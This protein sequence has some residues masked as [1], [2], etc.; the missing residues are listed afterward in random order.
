[1][2]K[3]NNSNS[4]ADSVPG[5]GKQSIARRIAKITAISFGILVALIVIILCGISLFL[6]PDRLTRIANKEASRY[7]N[8][9]VYARHIEYSIWSSFPRFDIHTDSILVIS[10]TLQ[11][12]PAD[13]RAA[14]PANADSLASLR[15][16]SGSIN[17]IDL[18]LNRY[19]IHDVKVDGLNLN[20][21]AYNDSINNYNIIPS[22]GEKM[23]QIPYFSAKSVE[24]TNPG[25]LKY[26]SAASQTKASLGLKR[27]SLEHRKGHDS[28]NLYHLAIQGMVNA[29]SAGLRILSDFPFDL[30]GDIQLKFK[31]FGIKLIDYDINL[32]EL[33]SKLSMSIGIG[34]TPALESFD[35][36]ISSVNL[37]SL[38]EYIP[39]EFIPSLQGINTDMTISAAARLTSAWNFSSNEFPSVRV[40]FSTP[41][42]Q[43]DY[44]LAI[45]VSPANPGTGSRIVTYPLNYSTITGIFNFNGK[46]PDKSY[47]E[48]PHFSIST[49]GLQLGLR[50][51]ITDLTTLPAVRANLDLNSDLRKSLKIFPYTMPM[52][53]DGNMEVNSDIT[54]NVASLTKEGL[55]Q[56]L[57]NL[58]ASG[59]I[60]L[61]DCRLNMPSAGLKSNLSK[62]KI[63]F[64]EKATAITPDYVSDPVSSLAMHIEN[65][66][67]ISQQGN[68]KV[69]GFTLNTGNSIRGEVT[70]QRVMGGLPLSLSIYADRITYNDPQS[71]T[72]VVATGTTLSDSLVTTSLNS[73]STLL[74]DGF[75]FR[76]RE[77][78]LRSAKDRFILHNPAIS[79]AITERPGAAASLQALT[80]NMSASGN[81][82]TPKIQPAAKNIS[83]EGYSYPSHT[84]ELLSVS[85][86]PAVSDFMKNFKFVTDL[87]ADRIDL[88]TP[89]GNRTNALSDIDITLDEEQLTVAHASMMLEKTRGQLSGKITNIRNF[90]T[91]PA[92]AD[93]P[94][95][96][97]LKVKVDT[98]NINSLA[99]TY[100]M[101]K[102][103]ID[104][105]ETKTTITPSDSIALM[106]P[107]NIRANIK[108]DAKETIY[109]NLHLYDLNT[110]INM[111]D[112][113][114]DIPYL[115]IATDFG[116]AALNLKYDTSDINNLNFSLGAN[117]D[118]INITNF[119]KNFHGL[120]EMM[121]EMSNLT[122]MLS[123]GMNAKGN[124]Y[125][126]MYLNVPSVTAGLDIE[127]WKLKLH[128]S[129]FI[130]KI[131]RMMLIETSG[132]LHIKDIGIHAR[133]GDNLLQLQPFDFQFDKYTLHAEGL[134]NFNGNLYYHLAVTK[135]PIPFPFSVN[136]TGMFH[137]PELRF[138][139]AHFDTRRSEQISALI[140]ENNNVNIVKIARSF[141]GA[142]VKKA[143]ESAEDPSLSL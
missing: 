31:P 116:N 65:L 109:M 125:P 80:R 46:S 40:D 38:L 88:L 135:S 98:I 63:D 81:T 104:K 132:D 115:N 133:I 54:F 53:L 92:S 6:T 76:S 44:S 58:D 75:S 108:A 140:E 143:A 91:L 129:K 24:L 114:A 103:G 95:D 15:S 134:N 50:A 13:I 30:Y 21:V 136:I 137:H 62:L 8:A 100:A 106:L 101:A 2:G 87:K 22:T 57:T 25:N 121:P 20:L 110:Q 49:D 130:R 118:D 52:A 26:F 123:I 3:V 79:F 94:L 139:G 9:D 72:A 48:I 41:A 36:R 42:G 17:I 51:K 16:F 122:G 131:T 89:G 124:I 37:M 19:V 18:F 70:S 61:S 128:Q 86:P 112:G 73:L 111:R 55:E 10:R 33:K 99:H 71:N 77:I 82:D 105:I 34:D 83:A 4:T 64:S 90:L 7:L 141:M 68:F 1:M 23:K 11:G 119:F 56:G 142:F 66:N 102:G 69:S 117:M 29:S 74:S 43:L 96:I 32:G 97:N 35:Y 60:I 84:P 138:G 78:A 39:K 85:L 127:G 126:D 59:E 113:I 27:L 47:V 93:N 12:I 107:R 28:K 45:P 14:L 5:S 120:L 67:G